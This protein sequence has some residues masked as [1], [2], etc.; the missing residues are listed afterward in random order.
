MVKTSPFAEAEPIAYGP[1]GIRRG[2]P[3]S[4]QFKTC[5]SEKYGECADKFGIRA[6][7]R[8]LISGEKTAAECR[9][10]Y[11]KYQQCLSDSFKACIDEFGW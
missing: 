6:L 5:V 10:V 2:Q 11:D 1:S 9:E 3:H 8:C 4:E 7:T